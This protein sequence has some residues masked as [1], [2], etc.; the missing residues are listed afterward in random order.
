MRLSIMEFVRHHGV[1]R[2]EGAVVIIVLV[3]EISLGERKTKKSY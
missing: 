1:R 2:G 3:K